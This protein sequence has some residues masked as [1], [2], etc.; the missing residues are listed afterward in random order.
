MWFCFNDGFIS[1]VESR[2]PSI[3][4]VRARRR[5]HLANIF[6]GE[7][8]IE[9]KHSDYRWRVFVSREKM[10]KIVSDRVMNINYDNF[11]DSVEDKGLHDLYAGFWVDHNRYQQGRSSEGYFR[12]YRL[13]MDDE[14]R[15][16]K[17]KN[18]VYKTQKT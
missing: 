15:R 2:D 9:T 17:K 18:Q 11:K 7:N 14:R 4:S 10:A 5:Q 6:P 1:V 13:A 8:I 16:G 12:T 3:L